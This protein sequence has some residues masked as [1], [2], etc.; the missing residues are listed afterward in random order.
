LSYSIAQ[1]ITYTVIGLLALVS[2]IFTIKYETEF[3]EKN[4]ERKLQFIISLMSIGGML[5][6]I[7]TLLGHWFITPLYTFYS[8]MLIGPLLL[9]LAPV[10]LL[11]RHRQ[12]KGLAEDRK[13][14]QIKMVLEVE[15]MLD[16]AKMQK[17]K[18]GKIKRGEE[19]PEL[20]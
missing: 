6:L 16:D 15:K 19:F 8:L 5:V 17:I 4:R 7:L 20:E 14:E 12:F 18:E 10:I 2:L 11:L 1:H 13:I 9:V 3:L